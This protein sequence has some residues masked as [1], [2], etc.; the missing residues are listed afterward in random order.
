MSYVVTLKAT[1][2]PRWFINA[3]DQIMSSRMELVETTICS[4][5]E[6]YDS[7]LAIEKPAFVWTITFPTEQDY[8]WFVL[9]WS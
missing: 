2:S 1:R 7:M 8:T 3:W 4:W 6:I 5:N 9:K